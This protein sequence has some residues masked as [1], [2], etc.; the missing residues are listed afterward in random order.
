MGNFNDGGDSRGEASDTFRALALE[1][2]DTTE[3]LDGVVTA[4][5]RRALRTR[6]PQHEETAHRLP[7][8]R[9]GLETYQDLTTEASATL[10]GA[11]LDR[12]HAG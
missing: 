9:C 11:Y 2:L 10:A 1:V 12:I 6:D 8:H 4:A 7:C 3:P 5:F